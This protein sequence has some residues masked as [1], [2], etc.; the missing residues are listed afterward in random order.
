MYILAS[1]YR[2]CAGIDKIVQNDN[3]RVVQIVC[4]C[5]VAFDLCPW[6]NPSGNTKVCA[7]RYEAR[8]LVYTYVSATPHDK[9]PRSIYEYMY[10][11]DIILSDRRVFG[12]RTL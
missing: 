7:P 11:R 9:Q 1:L 8:A 12:T 5:V 2:K 4:V 6:I 3:A 10:M